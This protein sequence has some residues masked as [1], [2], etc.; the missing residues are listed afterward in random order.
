MRECR[1]I[2]TVQGS[3]SPQPKWNP[4]GPGKKA[5]LPKNNS[6]SFHVSAGEG[7]CYAF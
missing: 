5:V 2:G 4:K 1:G 3:D 7:K 6:V